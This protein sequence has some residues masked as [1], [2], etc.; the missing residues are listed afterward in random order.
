MLRGDLE[1]TGDITSTGTAHSFAANSIPVTAISGAVNKAGDTLTGPLNVNLNSA[2][3]FLVQLE[4]GASYT[5]LNGG[6]FTTA[7]FGPRPQN[8]GFCTVLHSWGTDA[9]NNY[10][11]NDY[12]AGS[13][14]FSHSIAGA[15]TNVLSISNTGNLTSTGTAHSFANG[16]I[17]S[18]A[19]IG[20][21]AF[22]PANSAAAGVDGSMRW[23]EDFLYVRVASGWKRVALTAF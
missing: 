9:S 20:S 6:V 2:G 21:T 12:S 11:G 7:K 13:L 8:D 23:D 10:W 22:T 1:V 17:P 3:A 16:S 19:V 4:N 15:R 14:D 18:P 5:K